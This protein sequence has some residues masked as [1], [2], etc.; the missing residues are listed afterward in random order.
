MNSSNNKSI[1]IC[2]I[3]SQ[4]NVSPLF[5]IKKPK[6]SEKHQASNKQI[7]DMINERISTHNGNPK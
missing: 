6:K 3:S 2:A 5:G 4:T 7:P 1:K